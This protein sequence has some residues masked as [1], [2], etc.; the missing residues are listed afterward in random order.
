M[1]HATQALAPFSAYMKIPRGA[2]AR[3]C[4]GAAPL[5]AAASR[6]DDTSQHHRITEW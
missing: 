5:P 1:S 3:A 6:S 4:A 2:N